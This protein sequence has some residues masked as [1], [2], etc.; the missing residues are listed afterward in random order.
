[1]AMSLQRRFFLPTGVGWEVETSRTKNSSGS[2]FGVPSGYVKIAIE[3]E[4]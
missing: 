3:N 1:M 4:P 2:F